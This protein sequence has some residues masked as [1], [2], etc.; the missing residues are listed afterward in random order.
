M[1]V[2]IN[3]YGRSLYKC[4]VIHEIIPREFLRKKKNCRRIE[5]KLILSLFDSV[6][7]VG[8]LLW[9]VSVINDN[10]AGI[11]LSFSCV[12]IPVRF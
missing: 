12:H 8:F 10:P 9:P 6:W 7:L 5:W 4:L 1:A 2:G 11:V 3:Y